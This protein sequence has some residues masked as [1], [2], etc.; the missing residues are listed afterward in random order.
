MKIKSITKSKNQNLEFSSVKQ[1]YQDVLHPDVLDLNDQFV[2]KNVYQEG[3]WAG[4]FQ[5]TERGAQ[6][7]CERV[8][9]KNITDVAATTSIYRP[10]PLAAKVDDIY[11]EAKKDPS[12]IKYEGPEVEECLKE[13][14]GAIIFQEALMSLGNK[15]G[16]FT[17]DECDKMRKTITKR[18]MSGKDA[19]ALET[20][21][22]KWKFVDGAE[23]KGYSRDVADKLF[24]KI[25]FFSGYGFNKS[26]AA[27]YAIVSYQ[28]AY[29]LSYFEGEWLTAYLEAMS[30]KPDKR[31]KAIR[32]IARFGYKT[33]PID[34]NYAK[35]SWTLL[36]GKKFMPSLSSIKGIGDAAINEIL[37]YRPYTSIENLLWND[38]GDWK[39]SKF[40]KRCLDAL[41]KLNALESLECVGEDKQFKNYKQLHAVVVE[42]ADDIKHK[43]KGK[44]NFKT[45]TI[46]A[47]KLEDW[48]RQEKID[49][50]IELIGAPD[51]STIAG[52]K[53]LKRLEDKNVRCIDQMEDDVEIC[54]FI[55]TNPQVKTS[56]NGKQYLTFMMLGEDG[57]SRKCFCW[58]WDSDV[59]PQQY[60]VCLAELKRD[61]FGLTTFP[62]KLK[63]L[64]QR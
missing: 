14:Y 45:L 39:H 53:L 59:L 61:T 40:N 1:F 42:N 58:G 32:E 15:V 18:S 33:V 47:Q 50:I 17:L 55:L 16:G 43:K 19:A 63:T 23:K 46:A 6:Q 38:S 12:K 5:F 35:R 13:T 34:I 28:C 21:K 41:I 49:F 56:K 7:F 27:A 57:K 4:V 25:K 51:I 48:E 8:S 24:E 31:A 20:E 37:A 26:H 62:S 3:R 29:L 9:P 30:V 52:E 10:G 2:Y 44:E 22:L 54:W 64:S 60:S 36:P 11:I